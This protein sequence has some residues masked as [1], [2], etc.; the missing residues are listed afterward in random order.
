MYRDARTFQLVF[1]IG[2]LALIPFFRVPART[3]RYV[4]W[5][6]LVS[7]IVVLVAVRFDGV[8]GS[9]SV[10]L[11]KGLFA[12]LPGFGAIRDPKRIIYAYEL[13]AALVMGLPGRSAEAFG[14]PRLRR[15]ALAI[16]IVRRIAR[17][18]S[19]RSRTVFDRWS[20]PDRD[21]SS[22]EA[23]S[24]GGSSLQVPV[25]PLGFTVDASSSRSTGLPTLTATPVVA[26]GLA[27]RIAGPGIV[28]AGQWI[29][30]MARG[31][32]E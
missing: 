24:S 19:E 8:L 29:A 1:L 20:P 26:A 31:R 13:A 4:L 3:R 9:R 22:C 14:P 6:L 27:L 2:I 12:W 32:R 30:S 15:R 21:R 18:H 7:T 25:P 5:F 16:L 28:G 10:S 17:W 23:S 11:W